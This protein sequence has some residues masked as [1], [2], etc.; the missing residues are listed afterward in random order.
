MSLIGFGK[1]PD[2]APPHKLKALKQPAGHSYDE[3]ELIHR[4]SPYCSLLITI[5]LQISTTSLQSSDRKGTEQSATTMHLQ[6]NS[7]NI[8]IKNKHRT[9]KQAFK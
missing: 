5:K 2:R 9:S 3:I 7:Y 8:Y 6:N 4:P 1:Q